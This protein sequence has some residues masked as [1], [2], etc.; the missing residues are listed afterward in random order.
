MPILLGL[1]ALVFL[2]TF[3]AWAALVIVTLITD[4]LNFWAWMGAVTIGL[5]IWEG[6]SRK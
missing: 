5:M 1:L 6:R 4:P 3:V 2:V